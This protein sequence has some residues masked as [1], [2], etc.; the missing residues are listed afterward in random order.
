M[1]MQSWN[2]SILNLFNICFSF[3]LLY[4]LYSHKWKLLEQ[5]CIK[6]FFTFLFTGKMMWGKIKYSG[7]Y[8]VFIES[9]K[10]YKTFNSE[11]RFYFNTKHLKHLFKLLETY[12]KQ[13]EKIKMC[14]EM[15]L[16]SKN[17]G[18]HINYNHMSTNI[19]S[20]FLLKYTDTMK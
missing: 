16:I 20:F 4:T 8:L 15:K 12:N 19:T 6:Y 17:N 9:F 10:L 7:I 2:I 5:I 3:L 14:R 1:N 11:S 18:M 13:E